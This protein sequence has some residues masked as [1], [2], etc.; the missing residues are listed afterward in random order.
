MR[1]GVLAELRQLTTALEPVL[2]WLAA[3]PGPIAVAME[4][5]LYWEW[6]VARLQEAGHTAHAAQ[7]PDARASH[8]RESALPAKRPLW[9]GGPRVA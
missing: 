1:G 8:G 4:T 6:L 2:D 7:E 3:L 9:K 5:T